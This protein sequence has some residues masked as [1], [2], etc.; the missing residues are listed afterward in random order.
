MTLESPLVRLRPGG[1]YSAWPAETRV[2]EAGRLRVIECASGTWF[3]SCEVSYRRHANPD[4]SPRR[5]HHP[6]GLLCRLE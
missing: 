2:T 4:V 6:W 3:T 1:L 5:G